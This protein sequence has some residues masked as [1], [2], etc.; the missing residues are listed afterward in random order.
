MK[1]KFA[2]LVV[3]CVMVLSLVLASCAPS[4]PTTP[5]A[6]TTP[7]T[8]TTPIQPTPITPTTPTTPT[9]PEMVQDS[10]GRM[11]EKPK[12][13]GTF[14]IIPWR[15][16]RGFDPF[17]QEPSGMTTIQI[18]HENLMGL[19]W[20]RGASGTGEWGGIISIAPMTFKTGLVA[21]SY[22]ITDDE[23]IIYKIRQGVRFGLDPNNE[24]SRLVGGRELTADDVV[25]STMRLFEDKPGSALRQRLSEFEWPVSARALDK[26]TVEFKATPGYASAL[27][28]VTADWITL[29]AKEV[30]DKYGDLLDWRNSVGTGPY[31]LTDYIPASSATMIKNPNYWQPDPFHPDNKLP[32]PDGVKYLMVSDMSTILAG[33]RTGKIDSIS[34]KFISEEDWQSLIKTRPDMQSLRSFDYRPYVLGLRV[35][36]PELPWYNKSV[37]HALSMA[38]DREAILRDYYGGQG[39]M[40]VFPVAPFGE[41]MPMWTPL[42]EQSAAVQEMYKYQPEKAK[43]MLADAGYPNGFN[44]EV[45]ASN[46][47]D[48]DLLSAVKFY[49][50]KVGV[51]ITIRVVEDAVFTTM[52]KNRSIEEAG[53]EIHS[54][55]LAFV[56]EDWNVPL[57][58][59]GGWPNMNDALALE[60][61]EKVLNV[62]MLNEQEAWPLMKEFFK[63]AVEEAW[64]IGMP[65]PYQYLPWQPWVKGYSGEQTTGYGEYQGQAKYLWIDTDLKKSLGY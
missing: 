29:T 64:Y 52:T 17:F 1:G 45:V 10:M 63:H 50:E 43:Q 59:Q 35:D 26:Y 47:A 19:D 41:F 22:E 37:R 31:M 33:F 49:L 34:R 46:R 8:P 39:E 5:T 23:T 48:V 16:S 2:W 30:V 21:E 56:F 14:N 20:A 24:A 40:M 3:S 42:E 57:D 62:Y 61:S 54:A 18:T 13:G 25:Y 55:H 9:G 60:T 15:E 44:M 53:W 32:Y 6:P 12:Y 51:N 7:T 65:S 28:F 27:L 58:T 36:K 38:I 4:E 11:V